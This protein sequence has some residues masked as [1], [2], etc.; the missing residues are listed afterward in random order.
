MK[1]SILF[2]LIFVCIGVLPNLLRI[3][4]PG[5]LGDLQYMES[6]AYSALLMIFWLAVCKKLWVAMTTALAFI[7]WW[8][9][10]VYLRL[11]FRTGVNASFVGMVRETNPSEILSF[12]TTYGVTLVLPWLLSVVVFAWLVVFSYKKKWEWSHRSRAWVLLGFSLL[13]GALYWTFAQQE[14]DDLAAAPDEFSVRPMSFWVEKWADIYPT[15]AIFALWKDRE[16]RK[17]MYALKGRLNDHQ[18]E[19]KKSASPDPDLVVLI[20]GESSRRDRWSLF[21]YSRLTTPNLEKRPNIYIFKDMVT[22][23]TATRTSVPEMITQHP[24]QRPDGVISKAPEPSIVSVFKQA[25]YKTYWL[26]N[27]SSSGFYDSPIALYASEADQRYFPNPSSFASRGS[28]D[29]V[30]LPAFDNIIKQSGKRFLVIHTMGSHFNYAYRYPAAFERFKPALHPDRVFL[31]TD[32]SQKKEANN[33]YDNS[34][35]YTDYFLDQV[36]QRMESLSGKAVALFLSDHGEDI[37]ESGC[38]STGVTRTSRYSYEVPA[39][40]WV[41]SPYLR[42]SPDYIA[43]IKSLENRKLMTQDVYPMILKAAGID[44]VGQEYPLFD[45]RVERMVYGQNR[46]IDFDEELEKDACVIGRR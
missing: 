38:V 10:E 6:I 3:H 23:S 5:E 13:G 16:Y 41:N 7:S 20:I 11:Q 14:P 37:F 15:N 21:G 42:N 43:W 8:V 24:I 46:W 31:A 39:F 44:V 17:L 25:G 18:F 12:V 26:S 34:I 29:E 32:P 1:K 9:V 27:Q 30:L 28:L 22:V 2:L 33:A 40:M 36:F 45:N 4:L 19:I 35:L